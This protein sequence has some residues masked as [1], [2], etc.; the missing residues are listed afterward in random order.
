M[1][2][3]GYELSFSRKEIFM[4]HHTLMGVSKMLFNETY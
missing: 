4:T 1:L 3:Y 2:A